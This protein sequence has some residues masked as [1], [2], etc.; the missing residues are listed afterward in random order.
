MAFGESDIDQVALAVESHQRN[1]RQRQHDCARAPTQRASQVVPN[2]RRH[3]EQNR[4]CNYCVRAPEVIQERNQQQAAPNRSKKYT[5]STRWMA[6]PTAMET[7][8]PEKK[9][10]RAL[11]K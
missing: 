7:T 11:A 8:A 5:R 1:E 2:S 6:S 4:N 3:G 10:G 9:N